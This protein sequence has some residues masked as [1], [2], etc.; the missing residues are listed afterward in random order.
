M[1]TNKTERPAERDYKKAVEISKRRSTGPEAWTNLKWFECTAKE[2]K[3]GVIVGGMPELA[4]AICDVLFVRFSHPDVH[5]ADCAM[6]YRTVGDYCLKR[7][8]EVEAEN[9]QYGVPDRAE[10]PK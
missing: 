2:S 5:R 3:F 4:A 7:V 10:P 8:K 1:T 6:L 9:E